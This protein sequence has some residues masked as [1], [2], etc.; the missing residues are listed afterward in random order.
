MSQ[1]LRSQIVTKGIAIAL[2]CVVVVLLLFALPQAAYAVETP[3]FTARANGNDNQVMGSSPTR[4][5]I[6]LQT[7]E[8][9]SLKHIE[10]ELSEGAS[11]DTGN[12]QVTGLMGLTRLD[13]GTQVTAK[14]ANGIAID[15]SE[16]TPEGALIRIEIYDTVFPGEGGS[17]TI[18]G[19][20]E[21]AS[22]EMRVLDQAPSVDVVGVSVANQIASW[23][24]QQPWVDWWNSNKFCATF[25]NPIY[26]VLAIP[27]VFWGWLQALGLTAVS[28]PL[29]IPVGLILAFLRMSGNRF[30]RALG[31]IYVNIVRGTPLFLQMYIAFFGLPLMGFNPGL[32]VL[33]VMV[34]LFNSSAYLAEIF[35][36]GIQSINKGQFEAARSLGMGG[37]QTMITIII[38]QTIRRVIPTMT[39]EFILLYKDTSLLAAVGVTEIMMFSKSFVAT[40]G[41]VTP[42]IVAACFYLLV[43]LPFTRLVGMLE[44]KLAARD[45][46]GSP[47]KKKRKRDRNLATASGTALRDAA[48][49]AGYAASVVTS[50][51]DDSPNERGGG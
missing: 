42:Y 13:L 29:A 6:G 43:T 24:E 1:S 8:G 36:A 7:E 50:N 26:F 22:G 9:E 11:F 44:N 25:L 35:R 31:S 10:L 40:T 34:L 39:S 4:V 30:L 21:D 38:P 3:T 16:P 46:G 14:S 41:N 27:T 28:F 23:L 49:S 5:T 19:R 17:F 37:A 32:N 20:Y 12:I 15:F 2:M 33:A 18:T 48:V 45:G 47:S 51:D